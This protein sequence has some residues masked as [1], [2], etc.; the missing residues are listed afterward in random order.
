MENEE[1]VDENIDKPIPEDLQKGIKM[2]GLSTLL[3]E[4]WAEQLY[5]EFNK[6]YMTELGEFLQKERKKKTIFPPQSDVF[7]ML[8]NT[9]IQDINV[10]IVDREFNYIDS[11]LKIPR[12]I[13]TLYKA[14]EESMQNGLNLNPDLDYTK[15]WAKQ[16]ILYLSEIFSIEKNNT[17]AHK[18]IGWEL[19]TDKIVDILNNQDRKIMFI[20]LGVEMKTKCKNINVEKH[21]LLNLEHPCIASINES[22]NYQDCFNKITAFCKQNYNKEIIW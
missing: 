20:T 13:Q 19:F 2:I 14:V 17:Q 3:G 1:V 4:D 16:G 15:N 11:E 22:W 21:E 5:D 9:R 6:S 10:V 7:S 18:H 8:K 12:D